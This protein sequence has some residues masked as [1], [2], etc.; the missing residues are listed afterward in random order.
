[1]DYMCRPH[2]DKNVEASPSHGV[3]PVLAPFERI[4]TLCP[5]H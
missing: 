3:H 1:M 5:I 4:D 2:S